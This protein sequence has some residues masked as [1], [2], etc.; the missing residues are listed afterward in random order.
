MPA[1]STR[2]IVYLVF[3]LAVTVAI[4]GYLFRQVSWAEV[5]DVLVGMNRQAL[6]GFVALSLAMSAFR[7][8]R[9]AVLLAFSG[10]RPGRLALFLVVIVRNFFSDLLPARLGTLVYVYLANQ[11]LGVPFS[12]AASSF[13]IA[14][15]FDVLALAPMLLLAAALAG[16]VAGIAPGTLV[17]A[18]GVL[19]VLGAVVL[20][21][22]PT[23]TRWAVRLL[24]HARFVPERLR[25]AL[26]DAL[27]DTAGELDRVRRGG[28][29]GK[30]FALSL[31][32]RL[33]KYASLYVLLYALVEPLG[34]GLDALPAPQVL[35]G[36]VVPEMAASLPVSGIGGFGAYEGAWA[37][38]FGLLLFPTDLAALTAVSHHLFTQV[39]GALLGAAAL[40]ALLAP[41]LPAML[42]RSRHQASRRRR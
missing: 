30:V 37:Y 15:L 16:S 9:F 21:A 12:A 40:L 35:L 31:M 41:E 17:L 11:R 10:Y 27:S 33:C 19:F 26:D 34:Y 4:F 18:S 28:I 32:V 22:L 38:V 6:A 20:F 39:Y 1:V 25:H 36:L 24:R 13:A 7:T 3:S 5:A 23:V 42:R 29:Y 2:R 14:F 8:W